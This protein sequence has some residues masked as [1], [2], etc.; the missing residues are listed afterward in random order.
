MRAGARSANRTR[1][2]D[3]QGIPEKARAA[4]EK[5]ITR[6][7]A[8]AVTGGHQCWAVLA[9]I[10]VAHRYHVRYLNT[11]GAADAI[12]EKGYIEVFNSIFYNRLV[13]FGTYLN[14]T[15]RFPIMR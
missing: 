12:R 14:T 11:S 10:E 5:L 8:I 7:K 6:D 3:D 1:I 9:G 15:A 4:A 13:A 2:E